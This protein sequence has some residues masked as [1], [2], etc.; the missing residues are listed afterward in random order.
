MGTW[1]VSTLSGSF[2]ELAQTVLRLNRIGEQ[3]SK[4]RGFSG[5]SESHG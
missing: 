1:C 5:C 4:T 2:Y 3:T